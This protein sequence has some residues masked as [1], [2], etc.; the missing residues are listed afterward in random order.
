VALGDAADHRH[1]VGEELI[2]RSDARAGNHGGPF[3]GGVLAAIGSWNTNRGAREH[4]DHRLGTSLFQSFS[5]EMAYESISVPGGIPESA[6]QGPCSGGADAAGRAQVCRDERVTM[7]MPSACLM[8]LLPLLSGCWWALFTDVSGT[9]PGGIDAVSGEVWVGEEARAASVSTVRMD[10]EAN[11]SCV[12]ALGVTLDFGQGCSVTVEADGGG[13]RLDIYELSLSGEEGC[14]LDGGGWSTQSLGDSHIAVDGNLEQS[15][16][17]SNVCFDGD[18]TIHL[19][20]V[21][22]DGEASVGI[23]GDVVVGG[24]YSGSAVVASC[25]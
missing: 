20:A 19:D 4:V 1:L 24:V 5:K 22:E 23:T 2:V 9:C 25:D 12:V 6:S 8:V 18:I 11:G 3:G 16:L 13:Q 17:E 14:G 7:R 10:A 15:E 21:V